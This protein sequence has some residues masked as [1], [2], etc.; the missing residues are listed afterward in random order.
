MIIG[1]GD[2]TV[3]NHVK[4]TTTYKLKRIVSHERYDD[5]ED[6][7]IFD[8][9]DTDGLSFPHYDALVIPL[10]IADTDVKRIMVDDKSVE[11]AF[12]EIVL[13]VLA[14]GVTL[15]TMFHVMNQETAYNTIIGRLWIHAM[16]AIPSSFN[17]LDNTDYAKKAYVGHNLSEPDMPGIPREITTHKLNVD[18]LYPSVRQTR[19]KFNATINEVVSEEVDKLLTN[20]SIRESKYPQWVANVVM[21]KNKNRK[22]R[23]CIDFTGLNKAC[24]KDSFPLPHIDQLIDATSVHELLSLLDAYSANN[25]ILMAEEDQEKDHFHHSP[26]YVLLQGNAIRA[27]E[28]GGHV[29]NIS[30]QNVE[31]TT[32]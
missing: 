29:S 12:G 3:I 28:C 11:W 14:G 5:L 31:R 27:Q 25:Q 16:R 23:M 22:W 30:H 9:P 1:G 6:S 26:R 7:I 15:E 32:R 17:Q 8:K 4:F 21:V 10:C 18:P 20:G 13:P 2:D 24:L 19:R